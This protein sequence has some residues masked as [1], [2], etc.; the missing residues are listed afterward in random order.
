MTIN[1]TPRAFILTINGVDRTGNVISIALSQNELGDGG[2]F[3][4]GSITLQAN[5]NEVR[6]FTYLA[7]PSIG[8]NWARGATI[9]YQVAND[10]GTLVNHPLSGGALHILKEPAPPNADYQITLEVG[11]QFALKNYRS[12]DTDA[13]QIVAGVSTNRDTVITRY[14]NAA[15]I[16]NSIS[17]VPYPFTFPQPKTEGNS[18][19]DVAAKMARAA[20]HIL[21]TNAAGT[22]VNKAINLAASP[23]ATYRIGEDEQLFDQVD[24]SGIETPVDELVISGIRTSIE[25]ISYPKTTVN[26]VYGTVKYARI[27]IFPS[28]S[29]ELVSARFISKRT[30][31]TDYGWNG[32]EE[33]INVFVEGS[34]L[35]GGASA[36]DNLLTDPAFFLKPVSDSTTIKQYDSKN[37]LILDRTEN[38]V[39]IPVASA[40]SR[41]LAA[42]PI[43]FS[44]RRLS[45]SDVTKTYTYDDSD[46]LQSI[47]TE[48]QQYVV[49]S[50]AILEEAFYGKTA[51]VESWSA[52]SYSIE[53]FYKPATIRFS[54][55]EFESR[56]PV[57]PTLITIEGDWESAGSE[58]VYATDGSTKPPA[59]TY[60]KPYEPVE[61]QINAKLTARPFAGQSFYSRSRPI[62][63][64]FLE[65]QMQATEYGNT[66]LALLYGRKQGFEFGTALDNTLLSLTPLSRI[67]ILWRGVRYDCLTDGLSWSHTQTQMAIGMRLIV[68]GT[69]LESD[70]PE[71]VYPAIVASAL[72][73]ATLSQ[74]AIIECEISALDF[75]GGTFSQ[76]GFIGCFVQSGIVIE[77]QFTQSATL[78]ATIT[79]EVSGL[80]T[81]SATL[82]LSIASNLPETTLSQNGTITCTVSG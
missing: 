40:P 17:S 76:S 77:A 53:N 15:T 28:F 3:V 64:P 30:T 61:E 65:S 51:K 82:T 47:R 79:G 13:S 74:S 63:V 5:Y 35:P 22:V 62:E 60:R 29:M 52:D 1:L 43:T 33:R 81:Q 59:T 72:I 21:Y 41:N 10:S 44:Y 39:F 24:S 36:L 73:E 14:L 11:D 55:A 12:A 70:P 42:P 34:A 58:L 19:G 54:N 38:D 69:A 9:V 16:S 8:E 31:V 20:N 49:L 32:A 50:N 2:V 48:T 68:L 18:L 46:V 7:S 75:V 57:V 45:S 71:T 4:T 66:Y 6:E 80:F 25:S 37:R 67:N 56:R 78:T 27:R 23:V 26:I